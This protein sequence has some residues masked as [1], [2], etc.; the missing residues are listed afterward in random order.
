MKRYLQNLLRSLLNR[1]E[2]SHALVND[3]RFKLATA[4]D[5][6]RH[7]KHQNTQLAGRRQD[8]RVNAILELLSLE[9]FRANM[10]SQSRKNHAAG[11]NLVSYDNGYAASLEDFRSK[12]L[13]AV[14][15][16]MA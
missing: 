3:E 11:A 14:S 4:A 6:E 16:E 5:I 9:I 15:K 12:I 1:P 2:P 10:A 8:A 7:I 13:T